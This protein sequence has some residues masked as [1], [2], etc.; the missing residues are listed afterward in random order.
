MSKW[1]QYSI[2]DKCHDV[3]ILRKPGSSVW[4]LTTSKLYKD[5]A[6]HKP[7]LVMES[8]WD[9]N[10][11]KKA[12]LKIYWNHWTDSTRPGYYKAWRQA[13]QLAADELGYVTE[14]KKRKK[15]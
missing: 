12:A 4:K 3:I 14:S 5:K 8:H 7:T 13:I 11:I 10:R 2:C 6:S 15:L 9:A 1:D